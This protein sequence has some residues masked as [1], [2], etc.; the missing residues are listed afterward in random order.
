MKIL[1]INPGDP[2]TQLFYELGSVLKKEHQRVDVLNVDD[3]YKIHKF[4]ESLSKISID[5]IDNWINFELQIRPKWPGLKKDLRCFAK[6]RYQDI[7]QYLDQHTYDAVVVWNGYGII[8]TI[9]AYIAKQK[10]IKIIY[11]ENGTLPHTLQVDTG[12][13]NASSNFWKNLTNIEGIISNEQLLQQEINDLYNISKQRAKKQIK[14]T[15]QKMLKWINLFSNYPGLATSNL[16]LIFKNIYARRVW[17][18]TS[19]TLLETIPLPYIM[20]ALQVH[21]DTQILINSP[22]IKS[23]PQLVDIVYQSFKD[24]ANKYT[25]VVKEHPEDVGR[26]S[27]KEI[28]S[29]YPNI[30]WIAK[31]D[32]KELIKNSSL[33]ITINSSVAVEALAQYKPVITLGNASFNLDGVVHYI[34]PD[35][36]EQII[37]KTLFQPVNRFNINRFL[38][39][40]LHQY[41]IKAY[42][43]KPE[44]SE[45]TRVAE[46]INNLI[47][48]T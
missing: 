45:V 25:L 5:I 33:V 8:V 21:D 14:A 48:N 34:H 20:V 2:L 38:D 41:L 11:M 47:K 17:A 9:I 37:K 10:G 19:A 36:L 35:I 26:I 22:H 42:W 44:L 31:C 15:P 24:L 3:F 12:G 16:H 43:T 18:R 27:Y 1:L 4:N 40:L 46:K 23:M 7:K 13:V 39:I 30:L 28:K 6:Y 32:M 29:R